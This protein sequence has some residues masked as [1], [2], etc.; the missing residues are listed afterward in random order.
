M[1]KVLITLMLVIICNI[2]GCTHQDAQKDSLSKDFYSQAVDQKEKPHLDWG[3]IPIGFIILYIIFKAILTIKSKSGVT[4]KSSQPYYPPSSQSLEFSN[5]IRSHERLKEELE[6]LRSENEKLKENNIKSKE[7]A[8]IEKVIE[9][10]NFP[11]K[12]DIDSP[13]QNEKNSL[14][15]VSPTVSIIH[16]ADVDVNNDQF[17]CTYEKAKRKSVYEIDIKKGTFTLIDDPQLHDIKLSMVSTSGILDACE[18]K[19]HYRSGMHID[20]IPGK[21]QQDENGKW[22]IIKK[23]I[24]EIK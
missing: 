3:W 8:N 22:H 24:I 12:T 13:L 7:S 16:Y 2:E 14:S 18:V 5:L 10:N 15:E 19:G 17:V 20:I 11:T 6:K 21:I 9:S 1:R 23:A 4:D